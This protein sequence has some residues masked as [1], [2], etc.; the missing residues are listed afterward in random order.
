MR[1]TE[2]LE[3]TSKPPKGT[4]VVLPFA[5]QETIE[6]LGDGYIPLAYANHPR[7][8]KIFQRDIFTNPPKFAGAYLAAQPPFTRRNDA[9]DK[10][11][12]DLYGTDNLYKC[13]IK[14]LLRDNPLGGVIVL[15][16]KFITGNRE[17]EIERRRRFFTQFSVKSIIVYSDIETEKYKPIVIEFFKK[18]DNTK[19]Q[20]SIPVT[21]VNTKTK[22]SLD[23]VWHTNI[24]KE[25]DFIKE[26]SV[27]YQKYTE[28][29]PSNKRIQVQID[30]FDPNI[31]EGFY[32]SKSHPIGLSFT[33]QDSSRK[34][35]VK[36]FLSQRLK[37]R[38]VEDFNTHISS[39]L[40]AT[41]SVFITNTVINGNRETIIDVTLA[42]ELI[43]RIIWS[44][45]I[46]NIY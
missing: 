44:Y 13:F 12:F 26:S 41:D 25:P 22:N 7:T 21:I 6:W 1:F 5:N 9:E 23:K 38:I 32:L 35:V 30:S 36:G 20:T 29:I 11:I 14:M 46:R 19:I 3:H 27:F 18:T 33:Q 10:A 37:R 42:I 17:S 40:T 31:T 4:I 39:W 24:G 2:L 8:T 34:L 15:P 45:F 16:F 43:R 28:L